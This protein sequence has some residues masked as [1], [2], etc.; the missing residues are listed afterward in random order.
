MGADPELLPILGELLAPL[1]DLGSPTRRLAALLAAHGVGPRSRV[2][3]LGCGK[4]ALAIE[5][6]SVAGCRVIGI[7]GFEPF[8]EEARVAAARRGV[9]AR[10]TFVEGDVRRARTLVRRMRAAKCDAVV[11]TGL[12]EIS[13]AAPLVRSLV[14][15]GGVYLL[16]DAVRDA[17]H[18]RGAEFEDVPTRAD[19]ARGIEGMGDEVVSCCVIPASVV[20]ASTARMLRGLEASG[21]EAMRRNPVMRRSIRAF[22]EQQRRAA[23]VLG[24]GLRPIVL[25][26]RKR[27]A[28]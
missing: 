27:K 17:R 6:A 7:D 24:G 3:D 4:G 22:L 15:P 1:A 2:L 19:V 23:S 28:R 16:D 8:L 18:A 10:C 25:L 26:A 12:W 11:M 20:R 5:L 21:A 9:E 14:R 13:R